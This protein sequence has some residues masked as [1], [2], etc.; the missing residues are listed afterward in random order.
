MLKTLCIGVIVACACI[1]QGCDA[2]VPSHVV[3]NWRGE[4]DYLITFEFIPPEG[5]AKDAS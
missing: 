1:L 2:D 4:N 5:S 3:G